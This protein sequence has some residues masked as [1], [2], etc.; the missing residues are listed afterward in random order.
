MMKRMILVI[1]VLFVKD[2]FGGEW[3]REE[4]QKACVKCRDICN[5]SYSYLE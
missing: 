3:M 5:G 2:N 1:F 4:C